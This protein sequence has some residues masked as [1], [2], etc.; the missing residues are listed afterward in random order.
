[1]VEDIPIIA[2]GVQE[3]EGDGEQWLPVSI[4]IVGE[5]RAPGCDSG[6][7]ATPHSVFIITYLFNVTVTI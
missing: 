7:I 2:G 5:Q 6:C 4:R 1:M 3:Y